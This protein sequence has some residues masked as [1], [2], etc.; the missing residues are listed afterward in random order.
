MKSGFS[1][2]YNK[3]SLQKQVLFLTGSIS[4][5]DEWIIAINNSRS[6]IYNSC[7]NNSFV[8]KRS[9]YLC[10]YH[11]MSRL[12]SELQSL[13]LKCQQLESKVSAANTEIVHLKQQHMEAQE[14]IA[15]LRV[16][17]SF[18]IKSVCKRSC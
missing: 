5:R 1:I 7:Y 13:R 10:L 11:S 12:Q 14:D 18:S 16:T 6:V 9:K 3:D 15:S 4:E 8:C 2:R 17:V